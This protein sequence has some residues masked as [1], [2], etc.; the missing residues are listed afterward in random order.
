VDVNGD[1]L[2]DILGITD[3]YV[4]VQLNTGSSFGPREQWASTTFD[5]SGGWFSTSLRP[6]VHVVD[7]NG[8]GLPDILGTTNDYVGVQLNTGSSYGPRTQWASTT[9]NPSGGWFNTSLQPQVFVVDVNGD[10]LP[11]ILGITDN[12]VGVQ[13]NT[14]SS[15]GPRLQWA[16]TT[17]NPS[18][19][20]FT[21]SFHQH[22]R[23]ADVNGDGQADFIGITDNYVGVQLTAGSAGFNAADRLAEIS[24]GSGAATSV[25]YRSLTDATV[26]TKDTGALA[27][28]YPLVDL[29]MPFHV[30]SA[31]TSS[32]GIGGTA[33]HAYR[34]AGAKSDVPGR[35]FLGF[36]EV[37]LTQQSTGLKV[38]TQNRQDWPYVGLPSVVKKTQSS[39]AVLG[40]TSNTYSCTNPAT[41]SACTVAAGN[42]YFPFASQSVETGNDLNGA[43]LPA[44]TTTTTY[45]LYGNATSVVVSTGD[46]Y[47]K[48]TTNSFA[49]DV[50]NWFLGRLT[51][52]TVLSVTP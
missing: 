3:N 18:G 40:E 43:A 36:R 44:V 6:L 24:S 5:P 28:A 11:D 47:S 19:G 50:A 15:Y 48:T 42:R 35:G 46:G 16:S 1:G 20:W 52:S 13:L 41:G 21:T 37:E 7:V 49:N 9:F 4:G 10:G 2:P 34:Y 30:V 51:R 23:V 39:G 26:Y 29:Q 17:F 22:V 38:R 32:D 8:D 25:S 12:Y 27:A 31:H 45:D 33:G 14:G